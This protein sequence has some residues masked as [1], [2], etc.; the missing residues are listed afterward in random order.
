MRYV[1]A[2]GQ[3]VPRPEHIGVAAVT[4]VQNAGEQVN[5]FDAGMLKSGEDLAAIVQGDEKR[6]ENLARAALRGQ[7]VVSMPAAGAAAHGFQPLAGAD[8]LGAAVVDTDPLHQGG[9]ADAEGL[10]QA[11]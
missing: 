7:E 8:H 4:V 11:N 1:A 10:S 5:E 9:R 3:G 2:K 6:L